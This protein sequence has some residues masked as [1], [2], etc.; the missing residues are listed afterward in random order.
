MVTQVHE[1]VYLPLMVSNEQRT[2][3][4]NEVHGCTWR[5]TGIISSCGQEAAEEQQSGLK[6]SFPKSSQHKNKWRIKMKLHGLARR[7]RVML[8]CAWDRLTLKTLLVDLPVEVFGGRTH[9]AKPDQ[10][11]VGIL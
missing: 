3:V 8:N 7:R 2:V 6:S 9:K 1:P 4:T 5:S 10:A 11:F